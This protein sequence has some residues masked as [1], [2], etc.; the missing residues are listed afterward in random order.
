MVLPPE[1]PLVLQPGTCKQGTERG[2]VGLYRVVDAGRGWIVEARRY[3][4]VCVRGVNFAFI[5]KIP[6][7][8]ST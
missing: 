5:Y 6:E 2:S 1:P 8:V 3:V 7:V 4:C